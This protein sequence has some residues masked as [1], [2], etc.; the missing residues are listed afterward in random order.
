MKNKRLDQIF[1]Y[2]PGGI[3]AW[4]ILETILICESWELGQLEQERAD[5]FPFLQTCQRFLGWAVARAPISGFEDNEDN[6]KNE[7][8]LKNKDVPKNL[9]NL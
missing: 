1:V 4:F 3:P 8:N 5:I 7:D 2:K 9:D 6:I